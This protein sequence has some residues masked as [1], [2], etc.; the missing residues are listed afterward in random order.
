MQQEI[1]YFQASGRHDKI[2]LLLVEDEP[3]D[4]FPSA[5]TATGQMPLAADVRP[6]P[7][8]ST[9]VLRQNALLM[10][11]AKLLNCGF[12]DLKQREKQRQAKRRRWQ[13]SWITALLLTLSGLGLYLWNISDEYIQYTIPIEHY[14][15]QLKARLQEDNLSIVEQQDIEKKLFNI[16]E[17]YAAHK[18]HVEDNIKRLNELQSLSSISTARIQAAKEAL[19]QGKDEL[20]TKLFL[21]VALQNEQAALEKQKIAAESRYQL[22]S[23]AKQAIRYQEALTHYRKAVK[24]T[25]NNDVYLMAAGSM[26]TTMGLYNEALEFHQKAF[27]N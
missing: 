12:D 20:A 21:E 11:L 4:S 19:A 14:E 5:L 15:A 7:A 1:A 22:G 6:K 18:K 2:I 27:G 25:P 17:A 10:I 9:K 24:L 23:L 13:L 16:E 8:Q 26:A 3:E